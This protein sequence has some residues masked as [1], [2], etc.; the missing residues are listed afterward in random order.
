MRHLCRATSALR[1]TTRAIELLYAGEDD[2][3][4]D[5]LYMELS[6][7]LHGIRKVMDEIKPPVNEYERKGGAEVIDITHLR[8][9]R[10]AAS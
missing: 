6:S 4:D 3:S 10:A 1:A 5:A 7:Y 2:L 9:A 8:M